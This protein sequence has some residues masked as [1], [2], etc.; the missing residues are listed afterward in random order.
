MTARIGIAHD[1]LIVVRSNVPLG[2]RVNPNSEIQHCDIGSRKHD[3]HVLKPVLGE[4]L[5]PIPVLLC[6][7]IFR[8]VFIAGRSPLLWTAG[9][10]CGLPASADT[11]F[12]VKEM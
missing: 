9:L 8:A 7:K 5:C 6:I 1:R 4:N 2:A 10:G 11:E 3:L 12:M